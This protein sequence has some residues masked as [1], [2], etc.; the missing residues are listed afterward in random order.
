MHIYVI[1]VLCVSTNHNKLSIA[2]V[3]KEL[4]KV[5][6]AQLHRNRL[7][8]ASPALATLRVKQEAEE[9]GWEYRTLRPVRY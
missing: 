3:E 7:A 1:I 4:Q 6:L 9:A 8:S 2:R 5:R